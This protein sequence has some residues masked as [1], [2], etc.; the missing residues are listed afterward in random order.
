MI[1]RLIATSIVLGGIS[2]PAVAQPSSPAAD[3]GIE[4]VTV[5]SRRRAE[6][7]QDVP[8]PISAIDGFKLDN[9]GTFNVNR[10][11]QLQPSLQFISSNPRNTAVNIR[12]IGAPFGLTNDGIEQGVG[13]Y[14]DQVYYSRIAASTFDFLDVQQIE[15]LRGPQGTLYGKNTTAGALNIITRKPTF[16]NEGRAELSYGNLGY[17]QARGA[18]SGPLI[19]DTLAFRLVGSVTKRDGIY[20]NVSTDTDVNEID[21]LG[22]RGQLRF[23]PSD[24]LDITLAGDYNRQNPECCAQV[25]VDAVPTQ[26]ALN[27]QYASLAAASGYSAPSNDPFDRKLAADTE[28]NAK[29]EFGGASVVAEWDLGWSALTSVS[30]WRFWDW[31]PSN[32]R[33]F[34]GLP[35]T[36][37]SANPSKQRQW[38]Q[39]FRLASSGENLIDYVA[40][41][42]AFRQTIDS[43]G[44]QEQGSAATLW[45][46]GPSQAAST[47]N[48]LT[49]LRQETDIEFENKSYA[50]FGQLTWNI[51]DTLRLQ[52]GLR[53]NY[54][55]KNADYVA[56]ASGGQVTSD[57]TLI[58]R[59]NSVLQS[60]SYVADFDD[61]NVSGDLNLSWRA[62]P[63]LLLYGLYA[64]SFKSGG[65]NLSGIPN[66]ADGTP[67]TETA[68]VEPEEID[69]YE[70]GVKA[71]LLDGSG[72]LNVSVFRSDIKDYQA[73]VVSGA[74]GV[75]RGYLANAEEVRSQGVEADFS[76]RPADGLSLYVNGA[77][78]DAEYVS[79]ESAPP[80]VE[81][82]GGS[83]Q[84]VDISGERLPGVSKWSVSYGG[85]YAFPGSLLGGTGEFFLAADGNYR[86]KW[87]SNPSPS[88]YMWVDGYSLLNLRAGFR[89][90]AKWNLS[91]WARNVTDKDTFDFL[92]VQSGSTGMIAGQPAEQR[93]YGVTYSV[94]F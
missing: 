75:L 60:Q 27:R 11:Q 86:S 32:D 1:R 26:R 73:T 77:Y 84:F 5:T 21:N 22:I 24:T 92:S 17:T 49:G 78:A 71:T 34:T 29:Q 70:A 61:K 42:F 57:P 90:D 52:P 85:E 7:A 50:A 10:L 53:F 88:D 87:S 67:A 64:R 43:Q 81:L 46:L 19:D 94:E 74:V 2:V 76:I 39:E 47:P 38:T 36:T 14:V 51:S 65:V 58:G 83:T 25:Y 37:V 56:V 8:L 59:K 30:A 9:T 33:D 63:D 93:T 45:L 54:D 4:E 68:T 48:L 40:G 89:S 13:F 41:V 82:S 12:G 28:L 72:T 3:R 66:R 80:P 20:E 44:L 18:V 15:V 23:V 16:E 35:I 6:V 79:F 62:T 31:G 69:H 55:K 91:I